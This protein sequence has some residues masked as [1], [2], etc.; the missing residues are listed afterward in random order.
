MDRLSAERGSPQLLQVPVSLGEARANVLQAFPAWLFRF[1]DVFTQAGK[2]V[3]A[4][5]GCTRDAL[6]RRQ[7]ADFDCATDARPE[8]VIRLFRRVIPTG[9]EHGTVTVL[10]Q[11]QRIEVTSLRAEAG[12]SNARHPDAVHFHDDITADLARRDFTIN[13]IALSLDSSQELVDPFGG[14]ADLRRGVLRAV[15]DPLQRFS[16]DG[17][18]PLR[19]AR[20]ASQLDFAVEEATREAMSQTL[21]ALA[22]VSRERV[23]DEMLK[24]LLGRGVAQALALLEAQGLDAVI[25]PSECLPVPA[26]L[27]DALPDIEARLLACLSRAPVREAASD[28]LERFR[29]PKSMG[30]L[31]LDAH[32]ALRALP[33]ADSGPV[34]MRTFLADTGVDAALLAARVVSALGRAAIDWWDASALPVEKS[35]AASTH[36]M[37]EDTAGGHRL[38]RVTAAQLEAARAGASALSVRELAVGGREVMATLGRPPGP[39][40]SDCLGALLKAVIEAPERNSPAELLRLADAWSAKRR[41]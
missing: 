22:Q 18:R 9:I 39:W 11:G 21:A 32:G 29:L 27:W 10:W 13:A 20:F 26:A 24:L 38:E 33:P 35:R 17:L 8:E 12:Y 34:R 7:L 16:E 25:F 15:G 3:W 19:A 30:R 14:L 6:L 23:R 36:G 2:R 31:L 41:I 37:R 5:G 4:V 1:G 28:A 40:L